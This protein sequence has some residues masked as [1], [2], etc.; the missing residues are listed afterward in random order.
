MLKSHLSVISKLQFF[1]SMGY[2]VF[3]CMM[4]FGSSASQHSTVQLSI[5]KEINSDANTAPHLS[6]GPKING[7]QNLTGFVEFFYQYLVDHSLDASF[8]CCGK[9]FFAKIKVPYSF[10]LIYYKYILILH[11]W[12]HSEYI[13]IYI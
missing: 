11:S 13:Y 3:S 6:I 10:Y 2:D 1:Q 5:Q 12:V 4:A 8:E 7:Q 9:V